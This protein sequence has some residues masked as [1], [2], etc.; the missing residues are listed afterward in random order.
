MRLVK[1]AHATISEVLRSGDSA[2]DATVGNG[3]D[4]L[5][6]ARS[7]GPEGTVYGFDIQ[8]EAIRIAQCR[9]R[10]AGLES[11]AR[12]VHGSH[13][14]LEA[15]I[16]SE[17]KQRIKAVMFNLGYLPG[18]N[19]NIRT[20]AGPALIAL[21]SA[22]SHLSRGGRITVLGYTAHPGGRSET[23]QIKNFT[24]TLP[25]DFRVEIQRPENTLKAPPELIV[26]ERFDIRV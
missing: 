1:L 9:L 20:T 8:S 26:I 7:V 25:D 2:I 22:C 4:T 24:A 3:L 19:R 17:H 14:D 11:R 21:R 13:A 16:A 15:Q 5:F 12:L 10:E 18:G 23:E 6:L